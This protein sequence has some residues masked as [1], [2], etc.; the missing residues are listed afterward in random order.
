ME[1]S[2]SNKSRF[3]Q[4][5]RNLWDR[6]WV[7]C[8]IYLLVGLYFAYIFNMEFN[9]SVGTSREFTVGK[10][11]LR[12]VEFESAL[13]AQERSETNGMRLYMANRLISNQRLL[14]EK[15]SSVE[16]MLGKPDF[17]ISSGVGSE[18]VRKFWFL[19]LQGDLPARSFLHPFEIDNSGSWWLVVRTE[20]E[21]VLECLIQAEPR[22]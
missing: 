20:G 17:G 16:N 5:V 13:W 4:S 22:F 9:K 1:A 8:L 7:K 19:G 6:L 14:H 18:G 21:D 12:Q 3:R 15:A 11:P 2:N 10:L